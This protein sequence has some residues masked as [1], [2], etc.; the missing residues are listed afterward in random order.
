M[1][2]TLFLREGNY[3]ICN[4]PQITFAVIQWERCDTLFMWLQYRPELINWTSNFGCAHIIVKSTVIFC[5]AF[6]KIE[7]NHLF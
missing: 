3:V 6:S 7:R 5:I 2:A 1:D 4:P